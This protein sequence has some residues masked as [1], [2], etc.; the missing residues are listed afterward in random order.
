MKTAGPRRNVRATTSS[1]SARPTSAT[2]RGKKAQERLSILIASGQVCVI[3]SGKN[4]FVR[5]D[6]RR[7]PNL[8]ADEVLRAAAPTAEEAEH[9]K[10]LGAMGDVP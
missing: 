10:S 1:E 3:T 8:S 7:Y 5:W 4:N 9:L 2:W 6:D